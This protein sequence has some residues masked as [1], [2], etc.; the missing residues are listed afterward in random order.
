M[1]TSALACGLKVQGNVVE[2]P[3]SRGVK[4]T[5]SAT[6]VLSDFEKTF[7]DASLQARGYESPGLFSNQGISA[8]SIQEMSYWSIELHNSMLQ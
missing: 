1:E 7:F 2:N 4:G 3:V 6:D 8:L 5:I